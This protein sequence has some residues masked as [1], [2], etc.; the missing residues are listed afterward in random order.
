MPRAKKTPRTQFWCGWCW[1]GQQIHCNYTSNA[2]LQTALSF[3]Q[4]F[5]VSSCCLA[6]K[7]ANNHHDVPHVMRRTKKRNRLISS[8]AM[9]GSIFQ[10][11][12]IKWWKWNWRSG[13]TAF[14]LHTDRKDYILYRNGTCMRS[15]PP[16]Q[17]RSWT[18]REKSCIA[19]LGRQ[20]IVLISYIRTTSLHIVLA[21]SCA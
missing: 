16:R 21:S 4:R 17:T 19:C 6:S 18:M 5:Q 9:I 11:H 7:R 15:S 8:C 10:L 12:V 20:L 3:L 2:T 14:N 13:C 1:Q